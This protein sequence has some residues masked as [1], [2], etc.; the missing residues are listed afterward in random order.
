MQHY[1]ALTEPLIVDII[2]SFW[3]VGHHTIRWEL[4]KNPW[5]TCEFSCEK[6]YEIL[7]FMCFFKGFSQVFHRTWN[8]EN[9][10]T[11]HFS[12]GQNLW[13]KTC[14]KESCSGAFSQVFSQVLNFVIFPQNLALAKF[15]GFF[16]GCFCVRWYFTGFSGVFHRFSS[17][18]ATW[19]R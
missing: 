19:L 6:S 12:Q 9:L 15:T 4:V 7:I 8:F 2:M 3:A 1:K 13:N 18:G 10:W 11:G 5:K 16:T 14:E 17:N